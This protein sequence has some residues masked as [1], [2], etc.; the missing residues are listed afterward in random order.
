MTPSG[1]E[2]ATF[3]FVAQCLNQLRGPDNAVCYSIIT[4]RVCVMVTLWTCIREVSGSNLGT[5]IGCAELNFM[6]FFL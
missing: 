3:R 2:P 1:I 4:E 6:W 5:V